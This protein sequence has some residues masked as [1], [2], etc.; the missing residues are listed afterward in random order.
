M[1]NSSSEYF[2]LSFQRSRTCEHRRSH[3]SPLAPSPPKVTLLSPC[4][5]ISRFIR[6]SEKETRYRSLRG[7]WDTK[8]GGLSGIRGLRGGNM[9]PPTKDRPPLEGPRSGIAH[10]HISGSLS[11]LAR[12]ERGPGDR[13]PP[14]AAR[15]RGQRAILP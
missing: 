2:Y 10:A 14:G 4:L 5:Q 15:K 9:Q 3:P 13:Q 12:P 6:L 1:C 7:S 11:P 8:R